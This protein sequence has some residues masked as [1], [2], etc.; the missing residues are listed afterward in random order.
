MAD[1]DWIS[2]ADALNHVVTVMAA[3]HSDAQEAKRSMLAELE[4]G[5]LSAI[6]D[7]PSIGAQ[8]PKP[9]NS[10][11]NRFWRD[12]R[13]NPETASCNWATG[14][15][16]Y[17]VMRRFQGVIKP[18]STIEANGVRFRRDQV[19]AVWPRERSGLSRGSADGVGYKEAADVI[20][21]RHRGKSKAEIGK[22][23]GRQLLGELIA[24]NPL[25]DNG[26]CYT[27]S[28]LRLRS[29]ELR[30]ELRQIAGLAPGHRRTVSV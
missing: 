1:D 24:L 7:D 28:Y 6:A 2:A 14:R 22:I 21:A 4:A 12:L 9:S 26:E 23:T 15:F 19:E 27:D 18:T 13:G 11:S 29:F 10:V 8:W 25:Q 5:R 20:V 17:Q 16:S 30:N 3:A